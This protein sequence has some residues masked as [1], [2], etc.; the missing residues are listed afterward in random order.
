MNLKRIV[1]WLLGILPFIPTIAFAQATVHTYI[2]VF[3]NF[4]NDYVVPFLLGIAFFFFVWNAFRF[5]ILGGTSEEGQKK[6]KTL[7]LWGILAF[8]FILSIWGLTNV[9]IDAFGLKSNQ[10]ICPDYNTNCTNQYQYG[11]F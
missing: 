1:P 7:A 5:F 2:V 6:A 10:P 9:A 11:Y 3:S 4:L 8:V